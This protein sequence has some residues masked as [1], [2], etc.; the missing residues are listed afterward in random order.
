MYKKNRKVCRHMYLSEAKMN[1]LR[2]RVDLAK[3]A[4]INQAVDEITLNGYAVLTG[5]VPDDVERILKGLG[6]ELGN[7]V[8]DDLGGGLKGPATSAF[9]YGRKN[10]KDP[11]PELFDE[12]DESF[13][14]IQVVLVPGNFCGCGCSCE[15]DG[16]E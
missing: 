3:E 11:F 10:R 4:M 7:T 9:L 5:Y 13:G 8:I 15:P 6:I 12:D 16:D 2:A 1:E 14:G